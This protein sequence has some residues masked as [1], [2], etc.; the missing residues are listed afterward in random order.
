MKLASILPVNNINRTFDGQYA[1]LLAHLADKYPKCNNKGCYKIMD[2]SLIELGGA[3]TIKD[4]FDAGRKCKADEI[5]LPDVFQDSYATLQSV[6]ESL[7]WLKDRN[8]NCWGMKYM[9]VCQ[10]ETF[11]D[12]CKC[13]FELEK[14]PEI[15]C[16][17]IPKVSS[18]LAEE[19]YSFEFLWQ[20]TSKAIHLLGVWNSLDELRHYVY[21]SRIR[22]V[23]TCLPALL[24][25]N[26]C[27]P[28]IRRPEKT[29]DLLNDKIDTCHYEDILEVLREEGL[30]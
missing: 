1:M 23:D 15:H 13:F 7:A 8:A 12:F 22:S 9:A 18:T 14:I 30:L 5:I 3:V 26:G 21:P 20:G 25:Q 24:S 29:I 17:G 4:V 28:W 2:N 19:R 10:G 16:I 27:D 6:K 11:S